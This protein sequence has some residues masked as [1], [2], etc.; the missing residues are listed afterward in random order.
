MAMSLCL[1]YLEPFYSLSFMLDV[2]EGSMQVFY[3]MYH[4]L[5]LSD[6]FLM[7]RLRLNLFGKTAYTFSQMPVCLPV[8][9]VKV[10]W[11][12]NFTVAKVHFCFLCN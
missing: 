11:G 9:D 7:I 1:V 5:N 3:I 4:N 10:M 12:P 2:F 6:Y 8:H